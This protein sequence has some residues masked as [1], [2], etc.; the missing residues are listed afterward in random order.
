RGILSGKQTMASTSE[1]TKKKKVEG[2][3]LETRKSLIKRLDNWE[4]TQGWNEFHRI[5]SQFLF[6]VARKSGLT[7]E[8]AREAVQET[9]IGVAKNL[10]KK[11]FNTEGGSF[12][13]WLMNQTRWRIV[14]Q[15]R[16]R[17]PDSSTSRPHIPGD[18]AD[19]RTATLDRFAD[20]A[21]EALTKIWDR[22]WKESLT[23]MALR[24]VKMKVSPE[25]YQIFYCYVIKDWATDRVREHLGVSAAQVYLA[26]HRV[27]RLIKK[28]ISKLQKQSI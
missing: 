11:K 18:M 25:Q 1:T 22:E 2:R 21:G 24:T 28:E 19:R 8:E 16:A 3:F 6:R 9:F 12:K 23:D 7:E 20:P 13:A 15:F 27:G 10:R 4:D 14:D 17:R 26:K 5:Y